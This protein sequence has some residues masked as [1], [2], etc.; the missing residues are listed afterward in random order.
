MQRHP[1]PLAE[2]AQASASFREFFAA[3][4]PRLR[5]ALVATLGTERGREATA[6]AFAYAWE[7]WDR[8]GAMEHPLAYLFRVGRSRSRGRRTRA[9]FEVPIPMEPWVEPALPKALERLSPRQRTAVILVHGYGWHLR[10]VAELTG[11]K[12]TT[13]QNHLE[14]GLARLRT[15][16]EVR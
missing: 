10:E 9:V 5:R 12:P 6:E 8:V 13:V 16:L 3:N 4:E 1:P 11:V 15:M 2:T 7:H 14:R